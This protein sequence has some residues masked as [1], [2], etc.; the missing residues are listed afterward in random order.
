MLFGASR[1]IAILDTKKPAE[2]G[3]MRVR[4]GLRDLGW[5]GLEPR[6]N[7]LKGRCLQ[8][9]IAKVPIKCQ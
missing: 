1:R 8:I 2:I 9:E 6:T 5:L 4:Q 3:F 7:A